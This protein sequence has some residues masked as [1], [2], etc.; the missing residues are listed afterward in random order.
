MAG[1]V[2]AIHALAL[3]P[4]KGTWMAGTSPAMTNLSFYQRDQLYQRRLD[5]KIRRDKQPAA[6]PKVGRRC[7]D[8]SSLYRCPL[9]RPN[10][11]R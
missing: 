6:L 11:A 1:L 8:I 5:T 3:M 10:P 9:V 2:P 4:Q 7:Y